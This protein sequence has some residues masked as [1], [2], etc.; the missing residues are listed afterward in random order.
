MKIKEM[1]AHQIFNNTV[2]RLEIKENQR[3]LLTR[4][5]IWEICNECERII[6]EAHPQLRGESER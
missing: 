6:I 5:K 4:E 3:Y 2:H 1:I